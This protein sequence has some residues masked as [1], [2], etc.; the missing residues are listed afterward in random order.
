MNKK[1]FFLFFGILSAILLINL[2]LALSISL[3]PSKYILSGNVGHTFS[4]TLTIKNTNAV[5]VTA[6]VSATGANIALSETQFVLQADEIKY[7]GFNAT[8]DKEGVDNQNINVRFE[9]G[10]SSVTLSTSLELTGTGSE[11]SNVIIT[12]ALDPITPDAI[13]GEEIIIDVTL[14]N[15]GNTEET[16]SVSV[17]GVSSWANLDDIENSV[18]TLSPDEEGNAKIHLNINNNAIAGE[19]QFKIRADY[20]GEFKE[21]IMTMNI[22]ERQMTDIAYIVKNI[23]S[24]DANFI[25]VINELGYS[26]DIID[27]SEISSTNFTKYRLILLGNEKINNVPVD[28]YKSVFANPDYYRAWSSSKASTTRRDLYNYNP[29][30]TISENIPLNFQA[31]TQSATLYYLSGRKYESNPVITTGSSNTDLG[32]YAVAVKE[33]PRR[34]FFGITDSRYWTLESRTLFKNSI[35]WAINGEDKDNDGYFSDVDCNDNDASINPDAAEIYAN[36]I[37]EDCSGSDLADKDNDGHCKKG[38]II[39]N[40][41]IQ[42][43]NE[44]DIIGTDCN[45][46]NSTLFQSMNVHIDN[47]KDGFGSGEILTICTNGT[48]SEGYSLN[49]LDCNDNNSGINPNAIEIIDNINQNCRNDAPL[50]I[51]NIEDIEWNE[52]EVYPGVIDLKEYIKDPEGDM[53]NFSIYNITSNNMIIG[54][55]NGILSFHSTQDFYGEANVIFKAQDQSSESVLSNEILLKVNSQNDAPKIINLENFK[56]ELSEDFGNAE[57]DLTPY[58]SD[59][60]N[61]IN[62]LRWSVESVLGNFTAAI[63]GNTLKLNSLQDKNCIDNCGAYLRLIDPLNNL[64][65]KLFIVKINPVN[66]APIFLGNISDL[67][68]NEDTVN[69]E[70]IDLKDYFYDVDEDELIYSVTGNSQITINITNKKASF[71]TPKDWYGIEN[72]IFYAR[73]SEFMVNSNQVKLTVL[74]T[75]EPPVFGELNCTANILEDTIYSCELTASDFENDTLTFSVSSKT[76]LNCSINGT[77]LNYISFKDYTGLANC[78]LRVTDKDGFDEKNLEVNIQNVNDAPLFSHLNPSINNIK[79]MNNTNRTFSVIPYDIDSE[80]LSVQWLINENDSVG[81]GNNYV[82][83]K[84]TGTYNLSAT[85]TDGEL[86]Y[87]NTWNIFV[88]TIGDFS[89]SEMNSHICT[90]KEICL[91]SILKVYDTQSCCTIACSPKPPAFTNIKRK[92][93]ITSDATLVINNIDKDDEFFTGDNILVDVKV[94]NNDLDNDLKFEIHAFLY[95]IDKEDIVSDS[96]INAEINKASTKTQRLELAVK[97]DINLD[98]D[99]AIFAYVYSKEKGRIYYNEK[100]VKIELKRKLHDVKIENLNIEPMQLVC[101]DPIYIKLR[102]TNYGEKE[103]KV[104]INIENSI[105]NINEKT[106]EYILD[107]YEGDN[108]FLIKEFNIILPESAAAGEYKIKTRAIFNNVE[109]D[110]QESI[111]TLGEC[112]KQ[113]VEVTQVNAPEPIKI[114][115]TP[116]IAKDEANYIKYIIIMISSVLALIMLILILIANN[117][118][119]KNKNTL[120]INQKADIGKIKGKASI[121]NKKGKR[122]K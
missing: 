121:V 66:D 11:D 51:E 110:Y 111:I 31:Y 97:R 45:D 64:D 86:N 74:D 35:F 68:W 53:L 107:E 32:R 26:Y 18:M 109:E 6:I 7:L 38:Y 47:D 43:S 27:D 101:G 92:G 70:A 96:F 8:I 28:S 2:T 108:D 10:S 81:T 21:Q 120:T 98:N 62:E 39:Q 33:N 69:L 19:K 118:Y 119:R 41:Q 95:D 114:K 24:P 106:G 36:Y 1:F 71:S 30:L 50:L 52:D 48:I 77:T 112:K 55:N 3:S 116:I 20:N 57:I 63:E 113:N 104:F 102:L 5:P 25:S 40:N 76:N 60:D 73:D 54:I 87:S 89:C 44:Q 9:D 12:A 42:C 80:N 49:N 94:D 46:E 79:V 75:E 72:V 23:N 37:D 122:K 103:E 99:Y 105:L 90:N 13:A 83:N 67:S 115:N 58:M 34:V 84:D 82:F 56:T 15:T 100:F 117:V 17:N 61:N 59:I 14:K 22:I 16:Y 93:N 88:G 29:S 4:R 78:K 91:G 85:V 65:R